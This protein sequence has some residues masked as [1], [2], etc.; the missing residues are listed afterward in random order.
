MQINPPRRA[1]ISAAEALTAYLGL[2]PGRSLSRLAAW[3]CP[4]GPK[5]APIRTLKRWSTAHRWKIRATEHDETIAARSLVEVGTV[6]IAGR[7]EIAKTLGI[8]Q[9]FVLASL[10]SVV[11]RCMQAEEILDR[12]GSSTGYYRFDARGAVAALTQIGIE[13]GMFRRG[14]QDA[15]IA[16]ADSASEQRRIAAIDREIEALASSYLPNSS[17]TSEN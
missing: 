15:P 16:Q 12:Y 8:D 6:Q 10:K 1:R 11:E 7:V 14:L 13:I 9:R 17:R 5:M 4:T 3:N 2:G